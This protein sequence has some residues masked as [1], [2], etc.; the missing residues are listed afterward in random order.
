[1][2]NIGIKLVAVAFLLAAGPASA[3]RG[4]SA[5]NINAAVATGSVDAIVAEVE[6]AEHLMCDACI[7]TLT[8]L[9]AHA[10]YEVREVAAWW[11]AKR[12]TY[13]KLMADQFIS[14][15][16]SG[17]SLEVRNAADFLGASSTFRSLPALRS[18]IR[19]DVNVEA[20]LAIVRAT[21]L[22]ANLGGNEVLQVAMTDGN[23]Q[24]RAAGARAW[25][26]IRGQ[27]NAAP[28]VPL[29]ADPDA[30]VRAEAATVIGGLKDATATGALERLVVS[31]ASP[32]VRKNAAWALG[33]I[34]AASSRTALTQ[35]A[36]DKSGFVRMTARA[37]LAKLR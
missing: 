18:A 32:L 16:G 17:T 13:H 6:R 5:A 19:R 33:K 12:P 20:K 14:E 31:D 4:G 22:L 9:T 37:S 34:G 28:V 15:L 8:R 30:V 10:R 3:G 11:F 25:R 26:E 35:A 21:E 24:V 29:L 7:D 27:V 23:A 2:K 1:M 36:N